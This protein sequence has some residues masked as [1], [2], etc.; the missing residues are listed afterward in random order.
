MAAAEEARGATASVALAEEIT[1][2]SAA[3]ALLAWK[4]ASKAKR[5]TK[6][7]KLELQDFLSVKQMFS[8][9]VPSRF[10]KSSV[11]L[12]SAARTERAPDVVTCESEESDCSASKARDR[13]DRPI[14]FQACFTPPRYIGDTDPSELKKS[15]ACQG[16]LRVIWKTCDLQE[17]C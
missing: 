13:R 9:Y 14:S 7:Q 17:A 2:D 16:W 15:S 11:K 6:K 8:L 12:G 5:K 10:G 3:A 1:A 4:K